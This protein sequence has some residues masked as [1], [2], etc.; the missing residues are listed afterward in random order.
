MISRMCIMNKLFCNLMI[1]VITQVIDSYVKLLVVGNII[2]MFKI[3]IFLIRCTFS[4]KFLHWRF[5]NEGF[6]ETSSYKA[7]LHEIILEDL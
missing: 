7:C 2:E 3:I 6:D 1:S 4:G 5:L